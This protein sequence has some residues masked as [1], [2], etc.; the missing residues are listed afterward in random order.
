MPDVTPDLLPVRMLNEYVYCPRLYYLEHVQGEWADSADTEEGRQVHR[1]VDQEGGD[2]PPPPGEG[3]P[4]L[5]AE[6]HVRLALSLDGPFGLGHIP[7][8]AGF[9]DFQTR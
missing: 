9:A 7:A 5:A 2:F 6:R 4:G 1:R 3:E 8:A